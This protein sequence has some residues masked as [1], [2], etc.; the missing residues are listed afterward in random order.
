MTRILKSDILAKTRQSQEISNVRIIIS[1]VAFG[2]VYRFSHR[3]YI[4]FAIYTKV[5]LLRG[6]RHCKSVYLADSN[7]SSVF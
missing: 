5:I 1:E 7:S 3:D 6:V 4:N 2:S